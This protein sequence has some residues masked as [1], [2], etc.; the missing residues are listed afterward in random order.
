MRLPLQSDQEMQA[1]PALR[2]LPNS[3][4]AAPLYRRASEASAESSGSASSPARN[5]G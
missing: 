3:R 4:N 2:L 1:Q 5:F